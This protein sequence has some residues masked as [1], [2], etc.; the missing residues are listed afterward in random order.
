MEEACIP[1][2]PDP[3]SAEDEADWLVLLEN[4]FG[5]Y[6]SPFLFAIPR[7][8]QEFVSGSRK[9]EFH[10]YIKLDYCDPMSVSFFPVFLVLEG[11]FCLLFQL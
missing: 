6:G 4:R 1:V 10:A 11:T 3:P 2:P 5:V 8:L 9:L 7:A